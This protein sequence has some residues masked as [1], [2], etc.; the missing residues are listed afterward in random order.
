MCRSS[1]KVPGI[2][3]CL[4]VDWADQR[5]SRLG[6]GSSD[7]PPAPAGS[8]SGTHAPGALSSSIASGV[9]A[10]AG[11]ARPAAALARAARAAAFSS[12]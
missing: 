5:L 12:S 2:P 3:T 7:S 10:S 6:G 4:A 11:P 8:D 9:P 1:P